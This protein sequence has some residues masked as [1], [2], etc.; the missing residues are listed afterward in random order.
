M[1]TLPIAALLAVAAPAAL[2]VPPHLDV[3]GRLT[4]LSGNEASGSHALTITLLEDAE[5][6]VPL[7]E[8]TFPAIVLD[9]GVFSVRLGT[10]SPLDIDVF[11]ESDSAWVQ[12]AVDGVPIGAPMPM[13]SVAYS[14]RARVADKARSVEVFAGPPEACTASSLGRAYLDL[15]DGRLHYCA[16]TGWQVYEGPEGPRGEMGPPGPPGDV[17]PAGPPGVKGDPGEP[18]LPGDPGLP[19]EDGEPGPPGDVGPMGLPGEPG[20][21]GSPG[22]KGDPGLSGAKGAKGDTGPPGP[23]GPMGPEGPAGGSRMTY[24]VWNTTTCGANHTQLYT[25]SMA[26]AIGDGGGVSAPFCLDDAVTSAG[27]QTWDGAGV[28]RAVSAGLN[29]LRTQVA[30]GAVQVRCAVCEGSS[31][32]RWGSVTC[33]SNYTSLYSGYIGGMGGA[34]NGGWHAGGPVCVTTASSGGTWTNWTLLMVIRAIGSS[35]NNR[36]QLQ[37]SSNLT[38]AVCY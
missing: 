13:A 34:W 31:F 25:G 27:W 2:A 28:W 30:N 14:A 26:A 37:D 17:G 6:L 21:P 12:V 1:R 36:V 33:P 11:A 9:G 3:Q 29:S 7:H 8:E 24:T 15:T 5:S 22:P 4:G 35:G 19:G 20:A 18:G 32:V 38:C 16:P 10:A 23:T